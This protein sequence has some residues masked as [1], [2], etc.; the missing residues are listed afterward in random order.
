MSQ[1]KVRYEH[2]FNLT[3]TGQ[4]EVLEY[5]TVVNDGATCRCI[6]PEHHTSP[7]REEGPYVVLYTE[8]AWAA[9]AIGH[10]LNADGTDNNFPETPLAQAQ[11]YMDVRFGKQPPGLI[12]TGE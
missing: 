8:T 5:V 7:W 11:H 4:H 2:G 1:V 9:Q 10:I 6:H 12:S 3:G